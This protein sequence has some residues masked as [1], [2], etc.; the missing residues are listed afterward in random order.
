[1]TKIIENNFRYNTAAEILLRKIA[2][3]KEVIREG[4]H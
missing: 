2:K 3:L 1:M 4:G